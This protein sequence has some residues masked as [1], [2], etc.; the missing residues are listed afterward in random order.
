MPVHEV[1]SSIVLPGEC[2]E[3]D[4]RVPGGTH[5]LVKT[6]NGT[7][8]FKHTKYVYDG[9]KLRSKISV[10][11]ERSVGEGK[12]KEDKGRG[13]E[14]KRKGKE[15]GKGERRKGKGNWK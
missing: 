6:L 14:R 5:S 10:A 12:G 7:V 4:W 1:Q 3:S 9:I 11:N 2:L 8:M 15:K 13:R